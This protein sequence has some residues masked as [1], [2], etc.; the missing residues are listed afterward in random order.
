[1]EAM[2]VHSEVASIVNRVLRKE[3][4]VRSLVY[5]SSFSNKKILLRLSAETLKY[6]Q[7]FDNILAGP[8]CRP[9]REE[10]VME[11][12]MGYIY[13][14][15]YELL[16]GRGTKELPGDIASIL[17]HY[18][19]LLRAREKELADEGRGLVSMREKKE[20]REKEVNMPR[21]ARINTLK[22]TEE[23]ALESLEK[24]EW[25]VVRLAEGEEFIDRIKT[26]K[27]SE[28]LVDP[29]VSSLLVFPF[30]PDFHTYWMVVNRN[31]ILQDKASCLPAFLLNPPPNSSI[32]DACSAPG[33]KTSHLAAIMQNTGEIFAFDRSNDRVETMKEM[34]RGGG[35]KNTWVSNEDF[36]RVDTSSDRYSRVEYALLDPPCSGSGIVKRMDEWLGGGVDEYRLSKLANLQ[37]MLVKHAM[38]LPALKRVV[39]ST[40]SVH[41]TENEQV[42]AEVLKDVS[43][44]RV[45]EGVLPQ[46]NERGRDSY[47]FGRHCLRAGEW[48]LMVDTNDPSKTATNGFFVAVF[49]RIEEEEEKK[50]K[51]K[52]VKRAI[53]Q[54]EEEE[55]VIEKKKVKKNSDGE[56]KKMKKKVNV[57]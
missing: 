30:H 27:T 9:L 6:H 1:L 11:G 52:K 57:E 34:L 2:D 10:R 21:Y 8:E 15:M 32:I 44:F 40:C 12:D 26:L 45:V 3:R 22:W 7:V 4:G 24:E 31:I 38:S 35:V 51:K 47:E 43:S 50:G 56:K 16:V 19:P 13:V 37:A 36:L 20:Q 39:Y 48:M 25:T 53:E 55:E 5:E 14:C 28:V 29:H 23:E 46:W 18:G 49:E 54:E 17:A 33:M 42:V 41:E